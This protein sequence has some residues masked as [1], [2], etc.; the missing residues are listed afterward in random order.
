MTSAQRRELVQSYLENPNYNHLSYAEIAKRILSKHKEFTSLQVLRKLVS[1]VA[2]ELVPQVEITVD[3]EAVPYSV[4]ENTYFFNAKRGNFSFPVEFI[5]NLFYEFSEKGLD[6]SGTEVM[7]KYELEPYQWHHIKFVL[8]LYKKSHIFSPYTVQNTPSERLGE[9]IEEKMNKLFSSVQYQVEQKY[10]KVLLKKYKDGVRQQETRNLEVKTIISELYDLIPQAKVEVVINKTSSS[11]RPIVVHLFDL[12]FGAENRNS[13]LPVFSP[14]ILEQYL[15]DV[16]KRVNQVGSSD[17]TIFFGG[18]FIESFS[19]SNH[20][21]SWKGLAPGYYGSRL[22]I[23][24]YKLLARF[25]SKVINVTAIIGV[26]G[27]HDRAAGNKKEE[28][29]GYIAELIF[30]F[31]RLAVGDHIELAFD[32]KLVSTEIDG[33]GYLLTHGDKGLTNKQPAELILD[34]GFPG[35]FN[36]LVSGHWHERRIKSDTKNFRQMTCPSIFV[37]NDYSDDLGYSTAPGF[38]ISY[39][40]GDGKPIII[41]YTL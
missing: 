22:V 41:D 35:L 20:P 17:V 21:D 10:E 27:N 5:D 26:A 3:T 25:I 4:T 8:N 36:L 11:V 13:G 23:E 28:S 19:G 29:E 40:N 31:L 9:M 15:D 39:N 2:K 24:C 33:I 38:L 30:E 14:E 6:L 34:W 1:S 37:G 16:A 7:N 12:H 18:D 32:R